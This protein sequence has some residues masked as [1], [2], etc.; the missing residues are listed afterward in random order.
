MLILLLIW[1]FQPAPIPAPAPEPV[2]IRMES[3]K[4]VNVPVYIEPSYQ[5][6]EVSAYTAG[7]E[8]TG[9]SASHPQYGL[10]ASGKKVREHYTIACPPSMP[11]GTRVY[12]PKFERVYNCQD[13]GSAITEGRLDI[14]TPSLSA[15]LK[16]GRQNLQVFILPQ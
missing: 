13:R 14:Y 1:Y 8:S 9:K 6:F 11:F 12:I 3:V 2:I 10:T 15:A 5:L 16:F 4:Y 7:A